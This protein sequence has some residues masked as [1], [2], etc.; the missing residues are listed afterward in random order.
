M[1]RRIHLYIDD[2]LE[3]RRRE[4]LR[5]KA[6][7]E[8]YEPRRGVIVIDYTVDHDLSIITDVENGEKDDIQ[9]W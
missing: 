1:E 8:K 6:K 7:E 4:Y 5:R 3:P 2:D 9:S